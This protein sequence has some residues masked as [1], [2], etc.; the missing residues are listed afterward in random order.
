MRLLLVQVN[1]FNE[2]FNLKSKII[3]FQATL[4]SLF[5]F[6]Y[7]NNKSFFFN[8]LYKEKLTIELA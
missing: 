2:K 7:I 3:V 8:D 1:L 6:H 4:Y 5:K